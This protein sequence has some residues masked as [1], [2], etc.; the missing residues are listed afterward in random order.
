MSIARKG[1]LVQIHKII[2]RPEE[3][4]DN[5]PP[6]TKKV[7]YEAWIKGFLCDEEAEIGHEVTI[8]TFAGRVLKGVLFAI[9]PAYEHNFGVPQK[10]L[11]SI[12]REARALL[13]K[14]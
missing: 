6:S 8:E 1:D 10:E 14:A 9:S 5:I 4:A 11:L 2:L 12:G 7:P 13:A 3:R